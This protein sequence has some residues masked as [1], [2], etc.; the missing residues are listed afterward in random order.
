MADVEV[1][2]LLRTA[3]RCVVSYVFLLTSL[4]VSGKST[5]RQG[6]TFDFV[7]ALVIGDLVDDAVWSDVPLSQFIVA[8]STLV[9]TKLMFTMHRG[10]GERALP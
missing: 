3:F 1:F 8:S 2:D 6:T 10:N 5:I 4:R 9:L 7:L